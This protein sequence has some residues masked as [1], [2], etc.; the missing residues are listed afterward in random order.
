MAVTTR[1][2][3]Y[4]RTGLVGVILLGIAGTAIQH[5]TAQA[6]MPR[7]EIDPTWPKLPRGRILGGISGL[8][9]DSH[10]HVW[11]AHRPGTVPHWDW[12]VLH[13][14]EC[15]VP[16]PPIS[17][18]DAAGNFIQGFGPIT[19]R[20]PKRDWE[21]IPPG[22]DDR[23][24]DYDW[25]AMEHG[26]YVDDKD[27][28]WFTGNGKGDAHVLKLTGQGKL[29]MQIGKPG[30]SKGNTDTKNLNEPTKV[31]VSAKT[32]EAFVSDGYINNR[33]I[34]FDADTGA[35]R[36]MWGAYG[37]VPVDPPAS[38]RARYLFHDTEENH[39]PRLDKGA[40]RGPEQFNIAHAITGSKD[41]LLY[42]ADRVNDRVQVFTPAGKF[43]DE[44]FLRRGTRGMGTALDVALS[45]DPGQSYLFVADDSDGLVWVVDRKTLK[46]LGSVG[47]QGR[48]TGQMYHP[49]NVAV[50]PDRSLYVGDVTGNRVQK[51]IYKGLQ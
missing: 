47:G 20:Q 44:V 33:V 41:D 15:C 40:G 14:A 48:Q 35:Y 26:V 49:H 39:R 3:A 19:Y 28:V 5:P 12:G 4:I 13:N 42:V 46:V 27:N 30:Q 22:V 34:V 31:W 2:R 11:V 25:P 29:I 24:K 36:R 18:F 51:W 21:G 10:N 1:K 43:V 50:G 9:V 7:Y 38:E 8:H 16:L 37:N 23:P 17:E 45:A 6:R 32:N